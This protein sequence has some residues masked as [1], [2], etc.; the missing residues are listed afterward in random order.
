MSD[1]LEQGATRWA[2][3]SDYGGPIAP[4]KRNPNPPPGRYRP[5][6]GK[7]RPQRAPWKVPGGVPKPKPGTPG[8][9]PRVPKLPKPLPTL[10]GGKGGLPIPAGRLP[11]PGGL[12]G[13][14]G[15]I[16]PGIGIGLGLAGLLDDFFRPPRWYPVPNPANGWRFYGRCWLPPQAYLS[17][18]TLDGVHNT[19][20]GGQAFSPYTATPVALPPDTATKWAV[21]CH[22]NPRGPGVYL[23]HVESWS[24]T[25]ATPNTVPKG[26]V[27]AV[28]MPYPMPDPNFAR[29]LPSVRPGTHPLADPSPEPQPEV[30]PDTAGDGA[31][32]GGSSS[33][34]IG[35]AVTPQGVRPIAPRPRVP[36]RPREREA[37]ATSRSKKILLALFKVL[38]EASELADLVDSLYEALPKE[39]RDKWKCNRNLF[40]VDSAGQYGISNADCKAK[41]LWHNWHKV[42]PE[43]AVENI[44]KNHI[45]DKVVGAMH[46]QLPRNTGGALDDA[47]QGFDKFFSDFLDNAIDF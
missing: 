5:N 19:C 39:T 44:I 14:L 3:P 4:G 7:A 10:P 45:Y 26:L 13:G 41:A 42:D 2:R 15:R 46:R 6:P 43:Q 9:V 12:G 33:G 21:W 22:P 29:G 25:T 20:L 38:D 11:V 23:R 1:V 37:K 35:R 30:Q 18:S 34:G 28:P 27:R 31:T 32:T 8:Y 16:V 24:R 17:S 36:P 47:F 40:G